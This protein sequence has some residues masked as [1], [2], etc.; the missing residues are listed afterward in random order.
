[1][2]KGR[3]G[4]RVR[5]RML[6]RGGVPYILAGRSGGVRWNIVS[7][8][9]RK[10]WGGIRWDEVGFD[11]RGGRRCDGGRGWGRDGLRMIVSTY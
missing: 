1:M 2:V 8:P 5:R 7:P 4:V 3:R 10:R 6:K 11:G 9:S